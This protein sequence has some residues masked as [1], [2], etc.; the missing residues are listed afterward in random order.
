MVGDRTEILGQLTKEINTAVQNTL[1]KGVTDDS[2]G[3]IEN[4]VETLINLL[5]K[6]FPLSAATAKQLEKTMDQLFRNANNTNLYQQLLTTV[7]RIPK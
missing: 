7:N 1:Q 2:L 6:S 3:S 5:R 4:P